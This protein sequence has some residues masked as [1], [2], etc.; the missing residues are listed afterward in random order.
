MN[1][2]TAD[3]TNPE[4]AHWNAR[5]SE[6]EFL[7][8]VTPNRFLVEETRDLTPGR[9]LDLA[10]GEGRNAVWLADQ[11][12]HVLA[13][14]FSDVAIEKARRLAEHCHVADRIEFEVADLRSY[15]PPAASFDLVVL[16][17]LHLPAAEM[18]QI[19]SHAAKA[20]A[21]G[22]TFLLVGHDASNPLHGHGGPQNPAVL[23]S[24]EWVAAVLARHLEVGKAVVVERQVETPEGARTARD[25]LVRALR[26]S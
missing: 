18:E 21:P 12:W 6:K 4:R 23:Y 26:P 3:D 2:P 7:W 9:A 1:S 8:T 11:G 13:V 19:I 24:P 17:Y 20:V 16:L 25:C 10:V 14:D 22:G 5:Y 15:T